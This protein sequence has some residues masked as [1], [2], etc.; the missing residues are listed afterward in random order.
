[1]EAAQ[2]LEEQ[3]KLTDQKQKER[4]RT[5]ENAHKFNNELPTIIE[6]RDALNKGEENIMGHENME[7]KQES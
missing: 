5:H 1:M 4:E 6:D 7:T 3:I 2:A